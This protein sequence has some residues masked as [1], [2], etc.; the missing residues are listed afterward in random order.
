MFLH[1]YLS[2]IK[3]ATKFELKPPNSITSALRALNK[4]F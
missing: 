4:A 1:S 2:E 3:P